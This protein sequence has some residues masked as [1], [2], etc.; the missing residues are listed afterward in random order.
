MYD[1]IIGTGLT[2]DDVLLV[3]AKSNV[4]P[5]E[6]AVWSRLPRNISGN[7]PV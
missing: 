6:S 7:G 3:T 1:K 4:L 2:F 5:Q